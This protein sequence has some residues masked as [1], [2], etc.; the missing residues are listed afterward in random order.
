MRSLL[1]ACST[2]ILMGSSRWRTS[3]QVDLET[4]AWLSATTTDAK[5]LAEYAIR[6]H[7]A[8]L[9]SNAKKIK[10]VR[11]I[12]KKKLEKEK[13]ARRELLMSDL[14]VALARDDVRCIVS[15]TPWLQPVNKDI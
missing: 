9:S 14:K 15:R 10:E 12:V 7:L 2:A 5:V 1:L 4:S 11:E 8:S 3:G 6:Q 13:K